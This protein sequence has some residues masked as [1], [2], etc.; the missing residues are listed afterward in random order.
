MNITIYNKN[1]LYTTI[2]Y[3]HKT[4]LFYE[5]CHS[6]QKLV[7]HEIGIVWIFFLW[8]VCLRKEVFNMLLFDLLDL[9]LWLFGGRR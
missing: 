4:M 3:Y 5:Y 9:L 7:V 2:F 1:V 6:R 8:Y